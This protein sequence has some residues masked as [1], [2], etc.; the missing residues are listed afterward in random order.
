MVA[1]TE[2]SQI[3]LGDVV[4]VQGLGLLG[5]Y[6]CAMAKSR[7]ARMV[8]GIDTVADLIMLFQQAGAFSCQ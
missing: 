5:L 3:G 7:G 2:A 6:G 4:A 8:I 1:V